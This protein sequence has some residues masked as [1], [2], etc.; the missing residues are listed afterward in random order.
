MIIKERFFY[1][2][3]T[4]MAENRTLAALSGSIFIH[5]CTSAFKC[6]DWVLMVSLFTLGLLSLKFR[7][8]ET[9][10]L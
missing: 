10:P 7:H 6:K 4:A 5:F 9:F 3:I 8:A 2:N 1:I